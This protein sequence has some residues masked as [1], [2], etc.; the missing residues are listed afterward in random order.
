[1]LTKD[2]AICIR[3]VDYS[4]TSQIVTFFS[5]QTG[6]VPVMAKGAKRQKSSFGGPIEIFS[7][8]GIVFSDSGRDK[9]GALAEFEPIAGV[10]NYTVLS[11]DIFALNSCLFAAELVNT[12]VNDY[13]PH[14]VLFDS[15]LQFIHEASQNEN[16]NERRRLIMPNLIRFQ[17]ILL[18]EI[19]L[20]PVLDY[21]VNC[22]NNFHDRWPEVYFSNNAKG[23]VC[24]DCHGAFPDKIRLAI[25]AAKCLADP[26][27][28]AVA[29]EITLKSVED[30]L[31][32]YITD[33]LGR[34]PRM[35][36]Y[37][38]SP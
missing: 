31:I 2:Q 32:R 14:T 28:L 23:F 16:S 24:K 13:D 12:M 1:M 37:I 8:G 3:T 26:K 5:R 19:G 20:C 11:A 36:K 7:Y 35:A 17:L 22:R 18:T 4:E 9:L 34:S 38:L 25:E 33:M 27:I 15:L 29:E 21:C 30:I 10:V 6:K